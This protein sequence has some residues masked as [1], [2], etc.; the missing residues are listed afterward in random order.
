[1][2]TN[3]FHRFIVVLSLLVYIPGN[4]KACDVCGCSLSG[5]YLGIL[6]QFKQHFI[7]VRHQ[8]NSF[9]SKHIPS[10]FTEN[11][12]NASH[13]VLQR[14]EL[15]GRF[16]PTK[17][18]QLFA[19]IP[20][21]YNTQKQDSVTNQTHGLSDIS[22]VANYILINTGDTGR[23]SWK[24][25][26]TVGAGV[27]TPTGSFDKDGVPGLQI[28][29]GTWDFLANAIY[30]TRYKKV[31]LNIDANVRLNGTNNNY[32][33]GNRYTSSTRL[34]YWYKWRRLSILPNGGFLAEYAEKDA[35]KNILQK[36][37]GG[38]GCYTA[39]G[40]DLYY[41]RVSVSGTFTIPIHENLNEGLVS[42]NHRISLQAIYLF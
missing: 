8:V 19:F 10:L 17:R 13:D 22:I 9:E 39:L 38:Y 24:N 23:L 29:T 34:F 4:I 11:G 37:T 32:E 16:Y 30:T 25:T 41:N 15:W 36:Y 40:F 12:G 27:K 33:F 26:L 42:T 21:Q 20:Y 3:N 35:K 6:P 2:A 7:G 28:G 5:N 1:M 31:G 14:S 18:L